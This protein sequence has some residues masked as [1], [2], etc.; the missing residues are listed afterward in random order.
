MNEVM[1]L[2][3][4]TSLEFDHRGRA[5]ALSPLGEPLN[6]LLLLH[7]TSSCPLWALRARAARFDF[8]MQAASPEA[9]ASL[10][11]EWDRGIACHSL[12]LERVIYLERALTNVPPFRSFCFLVLSLFSSVSLWVFN[13]ER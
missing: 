13:I 5:V 1:F 8:E 9:E 6:P 11:F 10:I 7:H 12:G 2:S 4:V 3:T